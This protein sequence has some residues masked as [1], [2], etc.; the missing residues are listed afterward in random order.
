MVKNIKKKLKP[1]LT[2]PVNNGQTGKKKKTKIKR[3]GGIGVSSS[4]AK[5]RAALLDPFDKLA[6]D[7]RVVDQFSAPTAT[8]FIKQSLTLSSD[9]NGEMDLV[10]TPNLVTMGLS[11][12]GSITGGGATWTFNTGTA[13]VAN[14]LAYVDVSDLASKLTNYRIVGYGVRLTSVASMTNVSGKVFAATLPVSSWAVLATI[15]PDGVAQIAD[16]TRTVGNILKAYGIPNASSKVSI[17]AIPQLNGS[18]VESSLATAQGS[19]QIRPKLIDA[20]AFTFRN[21]NITTAPG[22][23]IAPQASGNIYSSDTS[24]FRISGF[25]SVV[26][27]AS[28]LPA[29]TALFDVELVYHLEGAQPVQSSV[30]YAQ[31]SCS[32]S[33]SPVDMAGMFKA[34]SDAATSPS[35]FNVTNAAVRSISTIAGLF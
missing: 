12:R 24:I 31:S 6:Y 19:L 35:F 33:S 14:G 23:N 9:A 10:I 8:Y 30:N 16:G 4:L 5:Y 3:T 1:V 18:I 7:A 29:S 2:K 34:I 13:G 22:Y 26:L 32:S 11:P 17:S 21:C 28:G 25:E 20:E 27:G 15:S